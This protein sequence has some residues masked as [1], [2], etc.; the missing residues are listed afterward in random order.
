MPRS[1]FQQRSD[2]DLPSSLLTLYD[3]IELA[4]LQEFVPR[5]RRP[6]LILFC[7]RYVFISSHLYCPTRR[8]VLTNIADTFPPPRLVDISSRVQTTYFLFIYPFAY[9]LSRSE[10]DKFLLT[11]TR[12][13]NWFLMRMRVSQK[14]AKESCKNQFRPVKSYG[15]EIFNYLGVMTDTYPCMIVYDRGNAKLNSF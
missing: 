13:W 14:L 8:Y 3:I 5:R 2:S 10:F 7:R 9:E 6:S 12:D 4:Y 1:S 11:Q 15:K